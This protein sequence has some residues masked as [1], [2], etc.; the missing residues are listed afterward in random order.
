MTLSLVS[1]IAGGRIL[2]GG[3]TTCIPLR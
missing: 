2:W 1:N 3:Y